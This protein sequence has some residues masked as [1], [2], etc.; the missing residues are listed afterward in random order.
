MRSPSAWR[1][2]AATGAAGTDTLISIENVVGTDGYADTLTGDASPIGSRAGPGTTC[3]AVA[4]G[5]DTLDGGPGSDLASYAG[6][7][8]GVTVNLA[9]GTATGGDGADTLISIERVTGSAY[10]DSLT[11]S[12]A[13]DTLDG[14]GGDDNIQRRRWQRY[15]D[16]RPGQR[17]GELLLGTR[18]G[19]GRPRAGYRDGRGRH[20]YPLGLREG[21][22]QQHLWRHA[23]GRRHANV[24]QGWGGDDLLRGRG[25]NDTL[26]G[27]AGLDRAA[28]DD[29]AGGVHV[30]LTSAR[31]MGRPAAT[32]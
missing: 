4:L 18:C 7:G 2:V 8:A 5:N 32:T 20:R 28:Y 21:D 14:A 6:A 29:A 22:R 10:L 11:G 17:L 15:A 3:S 24:L 1:L 31:R 30:Y 19:D 26:D 12:A 16:R 13:A 27:G 25:G 9:T 23:L